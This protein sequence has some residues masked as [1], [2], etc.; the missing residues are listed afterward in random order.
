MVDDDEAV[1]TLVAGYLCVLGFDVRAAGDGIEALRVMD[2]DTFDL[3]VTDH[4]MPRLTGVELIRV[5]RATC[6]Q[7]STIL[8]TGTPMEPGTHGASAQ[9]RKPFSLEELREAM[10]I[11]PAWGAV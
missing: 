8:M 2:E 4:E 9:L 5:L 3:V 6:P 10:P 1:R 11:A 7:T